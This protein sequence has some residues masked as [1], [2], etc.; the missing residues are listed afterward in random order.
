MT[1]PLIINVLKRSLPPVQTVSKMHEKSRL[2]DMSGWGSTSPASNE[3]TVRCG[4]KYL[5]N[6][7]QPS[8][9]RCLTPP[10]D[11]R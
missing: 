6:A 5:P 9:R 4:S 7:S 10:P 2:M 1:A 3:N 11:W 8:L